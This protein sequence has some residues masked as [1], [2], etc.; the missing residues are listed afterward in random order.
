[1][2]RRE[3]ILGLAAVPLLTAL[4]KPAEALPVLPWCDACQ[5]ADLECEMCGGLGVPKPAPKPLYVPGHYSVHLR[6]VNGKLQVVSVSKVEGCF[7]HG[8]STF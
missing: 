2:R 1:M 7:I 5:D 6:S 3:L 4:P 8:Q